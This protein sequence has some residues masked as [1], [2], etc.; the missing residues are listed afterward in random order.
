MLN[1][2]NE[3]AILKLSADK[4]LKHLAH[5]KGVYLGRNH[6]AFRL[7]QYDIDFREYLEEMRDVRYL[8][9]IFLMIIN[10][11]KELHDLGYVHRDLKPDNVVLTIRPLH[12]VLIDFER[13]SLRS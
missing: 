8:G 4:D 13:A 12:A 1:L 2:V 9:K 3:Y 7:H 5:L 11:L 6:V 10:G